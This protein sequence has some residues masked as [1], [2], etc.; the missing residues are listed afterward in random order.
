MNNCR[1]VG[2]VL[3]SCY[4]IF[5]VTASLPELGFADESSN[6]ELHRFGV[7][8]AIDEPLPSIS[9]GNFA[10]NLGDFLRL[11]IGIG[12]WEDDWNSSNMYLNEV[13]GETAG[14]G[15]RL[16]VPG[17]SLSP[18]LGAGYSWVSFQSPVSVSGSFYDGRND[19]LR[20]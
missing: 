6:R 10:Y 1:Q 2:L 20:K 13:H 3:L 19:Q 17:W 9:A 18:T 4:L 8:F 16:F 5:S 7:M 14:A 11:S 15:F 12:Q